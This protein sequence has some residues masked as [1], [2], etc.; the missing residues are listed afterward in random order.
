LRDGGWVVVLCF[1]LYVVLWLKSYYG[2]LF[3]VYY[4]SQILHFY[5]YISFL[6]STMVV[7]V[8]GLSLVLKNTKQ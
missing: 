2:V 4:C 5:F 3:T 8:V 6:I 7:V 1:V